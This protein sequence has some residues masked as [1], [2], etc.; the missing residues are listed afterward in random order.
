MSGP[1]L[2]QTNG[3]SFRKGALL[4]FS[5]QL[6]F[7][8]FWDMTLNLPMLHDNTAVSHR[9]GAGNPVTRRHFAVEQKL[10]STLLIC[11]NFHLKELQR[12]P[13]P[14]FLMP[15]KK[16]H[17]PSSAKV[18]GFHALLSGG[19]IS[20]LF[21]S[22]TLS[23]QPPEQPQLRTHYPNCVITTFH[24]LLPHKSRHTSECVCGV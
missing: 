11:H 8:Y 10:E 1:L 20:S 3:L 21:R 2:N 23:R 19:S 9:R 17:T 6:R 16:A 14:Y 13:L 24:K 7:Q 5:K 15:F 4:S 12:K 22:A 18:G